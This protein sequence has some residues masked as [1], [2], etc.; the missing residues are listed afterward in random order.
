MDPP[1]N[2]NKV[3]SYIKEYDEKIVWISNINLDY[4]LDKKLGHYWY[5]YVTRDVISDVTEENYTHI[6]QIQS[7]MNKRAQ[8]GT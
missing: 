5:N 1:S 3:N 8:G 4:I 6:I 2:I 7:T